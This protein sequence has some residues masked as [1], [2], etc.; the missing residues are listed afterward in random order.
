MSQTGGEYTI[1]K[2]ANPIHLVDETHFMGANKNSNEVKWPGKP[3]SQ[4]SSKAAAY[5]KII[6][7]F[8][9]EQR[10]SQSNGQN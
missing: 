10:S 6:S 9:T 4:I 7:S 3:E 1:P 2:D 5:A 8:I